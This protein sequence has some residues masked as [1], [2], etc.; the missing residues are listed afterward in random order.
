MYRPHPH[1]ARR[2]DVHRI[3]V[4]GALVAW[5]AV[6]IP[7][8]A[9]AAPCL[10]Y[11]PGFTGGDGS[12]ADPYQIATLD[13]FDLLQSES[14]AWS[15]EFLQTA[16]LAL[17]A[18]T[19]GSSNIADPI[20]DAGTPF[21]GVYDG[22]GHS[23]TGLTIVGDGNGDLGL[24]GYVSGAT[25]KNL[26][27]VDPSVTATFDGSTGDKRVGT[28]AGYA[29]GSTITDIVVSVAQ[30]V[31]YEKAG[32][33]IG[34]GVDM[35]EMS[36][37]EAESDIVRVA[38]GEGYQIGGLAGVLNEG[39]APTTLV[40]SDVVVTTTIDAN[41]ELGGV[42]G[43]P[44]ASFAAE[45]VVVTATITARSYGMGGF[46]GYNDPGSVDS[47]ITDALITG[48]LTGTSE[49]G[50]VLGVVDRIVLDTVVVDA[51]I[52]GENASNTRCYAG[53]A[54]DLDDFN[55]IDTNVFHSGTVTVD[56]NPT[57]TCGPLPPTVTV[58]APSFELA[59][60]EPVPDLIGVGAYDADGNP[61]E[62]DIEPVCTSDDGTGNPVTSSTA[63]GVYDVVCEG[64]V[65]WGALVA[66]FVAGTITITETPETTTTTTVA[67][68]TTAPETTVPVTTAA[69]TTVPTGV[70][71]PTG[72]DPVSAVLAVL[73]VGLG[74]GLLLTA[75]RRLV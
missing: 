22:G 20:G 62:F 21:D 57:V 71:P 40:V 70:L 58:T 23:I 39:S 29:E 73:L 7:G 10:G 2:H 16:D 48:D 24:F 17:P 28:L 8:N 1:L 61:V 14:S 3:A 33:V 31:V 27:L 43:Y 69:T 18:P 51:T 67:P 41:N 64:G 30:M 75:R 65:V 26:V 38:D 47:S 11:D 72:S 25:L 19:P 34:E 56:P 6:M 59:A 50:G 5:L 37:I 36:R 55:V 35:V 12:S 49:V 54:D 46:I 42:F 32:G 53:D 4:A 60:G 66:S 68:S 15:C 9:S 13:D 74:G 52:V 63:P 45:R 44:G